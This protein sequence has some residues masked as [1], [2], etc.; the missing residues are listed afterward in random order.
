MQPAPGEVADLVGRAA[1]GDQRAWDAL[2]LRYA[3]LVWAVCRAHRLSDS[4][5]ADVSQ[6]TWL[7]LVENLGRLTEPDRA[8]AWLATTAR[9]EC[10][11]VVRG[12][13]RETP[14]EHET[15]DVSGPSSLPEPEAVAV[16]AERDEILRRAL[17]GATPACRRLLRVLAADPPPAYADVAE[18]LG[19]PVGSIGPT[20]G[21]CL[22]A[23]RQ[24]LAAAGISG[25]TS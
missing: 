11:R 21:R 17:D 9:R 14:T 2:V 1:A 25:A 4:D 5:A 22:K 20:R 23:L 18:A 16:T 13:D 6:T 3:G 19:I 10:L 7:R 24:Q 12:R 8:G 15:L